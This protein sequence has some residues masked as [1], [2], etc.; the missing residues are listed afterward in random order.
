[1]GKVREVC[2]SCQYCQG[3][4]II[5]ESDSQV[6][7]KTQERLDSLI[8]GHLATFFSYDLPRRRKMQKEAVWDYLC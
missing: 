4:Y 1:M 6:V 7:V 3:G 8:H 5:S 2:S